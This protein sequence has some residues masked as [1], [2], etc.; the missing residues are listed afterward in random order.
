MDMQFGEAL[1]GFDAALR[2]FR[3]NLNEEVSH[4]VFEHAEEWTSLL[5]HKLL[6]HLG[7]EGCLVAAVA[8]GT[9]TGKSTVF[10]ML[11]GENTS[12]V[13]NTA[14][15]T[16]RPVV[17]C[18]T[19]RY[20]QCLEGDLFSE[21]NTCNLDKAESVISGDGSPEDL[22]VT[23]RNSLPDHLI[24]LDTPDVDSIDQKNWVVADNIRSAG[25]VIIAVLTGEKYKDE[26]VVQFFRQAHEAG[27][28]VLPLMNKA[29]PKNDYEVARVQLADFIEDVGLE[30]PLC[31]VA[32]HDFSLE[33]DFTAQ[34]V[35]A[36]DD[37]VTLR[38][39]LESLNVQAIKEQVYRDTVARFAEETTSFLAQAD[40]IAEGMRQVVDEFEHRAA[41]YANHYDPEP[42]EKV[43][44][45][46]HS[47][48]KEH[49][50]FLSR[51][52]GKIGSF[53]GRGV[54]PVR[55]ALSQAWK[56]RITL[57]EA[58]APPTEEE[59]RVRHT[60][61]LEIETRNLA[62]SYTESA[63]SLNAPVAALVSAPLKDLDIEGM[64]QPVLKETFQADSISE[65]FHDH[66]ERTLK[67]WWEKHTVRRHVLLE[68]DAILVL[69]P[70]A[71]AVPLSLYTGGVGAPEV[72]AV[73]GIAAGDFFAQVVIH[74]FSDQWVD[75]IT[76]W[77][78]EQRSA[79]REALLE[80]V[81]APV[82]ASL[83]AALVP[84]ENENFEALR[85]YQTQCRPA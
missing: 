40:A 41:D 54:L 44:R 49:R 81:T 31:F 72:S 68:L 11:L 67:V 20:D 73:A 34:T 14:A 26:R 35:R 47:F 30:K 64:L 65:A 33:E 13:R 15:A 58:E 2:G 8:G 16:C 18:N 66:A 39:Y 27:R 12:P 57:E 69:T 3:A 32:P 1:S 78:E 56:R 79:F 45:L 53:V 38:D 23:R 75:L 29:N 43:G 48:I 63:R 25:D 5:R 77:R 7:G 10:N 21:F 71:I 83:R 61:K 70:T 74:Q 82:L 52:L 6:P 46:L 24:L 50:G 85:R 19:H 42:D 51:N 4:C 80:H 37:P 9:N 55:N 60:Q 28:I 22:F 17:A 84:F 76:P 36:L 59:I 62:L